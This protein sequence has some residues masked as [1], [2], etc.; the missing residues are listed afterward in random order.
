MH[1]VTEASAHSAP[2]RGNGAAKWAPVHCSKGVEGSGAGSV[3]R[4]SEDQQPAHPLR[5][6]WRLAGG[7]WGRGEPLISWLF[8]AVLLLIVLL[9]L[10]AS[11]GM[12]VWY[13]VIFDALQSRESNTVL[14]LSLLYL[15]L[16]AGSVLVSVTQLRMR[17]SI[18]RRWRTWLNHRLLD[19]WLCDGRCYQLDLVGGPHSNPEGRIAEDARI[20]TEAPVELAIGLTTAVLSAATFIV[21]LWTVGGAV[22]VEIAGAAVTVPGFLVVAAAVYAALASGTMFLI[23]RRLIVASERKSQA[24]AEYRYGLTRLREDAEGIALLEGEHEERRGAERSFRAVVGAWRDVC[25]QSMRTTVVSQTSGYTA[26]IL[27]IILCAPKFLDGALTL[28][29]VMQA[30]SAFVLV[31]SALNWMVDNYPRLAEWVAAARRV[32]ALDMSLAA[33]ARAQAERAGRIERGDHPHAALRLRDVSVLRADGVALVAGAELS[34]MPGEKLLLTGAAGTGKSTLVR[35]LAGAWPWGRGRIEVRAG[36]RLLVLSQRAYLPAGSLRR[37][38]SY[39]DAAD[40][41]SAGEISAALQKVDLGHL[42]AH[43]DEDA[44]WDRILSGGEKQRLA[45]ARVFLMRPDIVVLDEATAALDLP[46]QDQLMKRLMR[47]LKDATVVSVGHRPELAAFHDRTVVLSS[48]VW[49][50]TLAS[51]VRHRPEPGRVEL[52]RE[53]AR[54]AGDPCLWP[55]R[56][57]AFEPVALQ[58]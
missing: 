52:L 11:Y 22:T 29:E 39:P 26:P 42:A 33:L 37:V 56:R 8:C 40:N 49:G 55:P 48:G 38:V 2:E 54:S 15:P 45:F 46:S 25:L 34:I 13:R 10:A 58:G 30:A 27:P 9:A 41:R 1:H 36:A 31:Q 6:F 16:L 57:R 53:P 43:L 4:G 7:F 19:R 14:S 18:Q 24:E 44:P 21:V 20:A 51:D 17:M 23:G 50:A 47:E 12:N 32:A 28:G 35:A 5:S 3:S